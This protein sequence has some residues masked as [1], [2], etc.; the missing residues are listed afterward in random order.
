MCVI[1]LSLFYTI[2]PL[3]AETDK[4][5]TF[6]KWCERKLGFVMVLFLFVESQLHFKNVHLQFHYYTKEKKHSTLLKI[7]D[8]SALISQISQYFFHS[9]KN[10]LNTIEYATASLVVMLF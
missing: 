2:V 6:F 1:L 10:G 7:Q 4:P 5:T 8:C 9:N 3:K